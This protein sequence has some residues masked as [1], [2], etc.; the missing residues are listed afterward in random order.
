MCP[1]LSSIG[2]PVPPGCCSRGLA[3]RDPS[4]AGCPVASIRVQS[5]ESALLWSRDA[6]PAALSPLVPVRLRCF[7]RPGGPT[8]CCSAP[9][10]RLHRNVPLAGDSFAGLAPVAPMVGDDPRRVPSSAAR[11]LRGRSRGA[12]CTELGAVLTALEAQACANSFREQHEGRGERH[13]ASPGSDSPTASDNS[14]EGGRNH[15]PAPPRMLSL[16][17]S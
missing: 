1:G 17:L 6:L 9:A 2:S 8:G 4:L 3:E 10:G 15:S 5:V 14:A 11:T 7:R 13:A 16:A 12:E